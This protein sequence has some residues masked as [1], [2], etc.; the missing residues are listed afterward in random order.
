M[1]VA[2]SSRRHHQPPKRGMGDWSEAV[3]EV[4]TSLHAMSL[5][6]KSNFELGDLTRD[7][8]VLDLVVIGR[9]TE[10]WLRGEKS[11][12]LPRHARSSSAS[13]TNSP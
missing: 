2:S 12:P 4:L 9:L 10:K 13:Q 3:V 1:Q 7:G 8:T 5:E 6:D 11:P